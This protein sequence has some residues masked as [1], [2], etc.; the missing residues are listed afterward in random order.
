ML[1]LSFLYKISINLNNFFLIFLLLLVSIYIGF[2]IYY[3]Y[4]KLKK[5]LIIKKQKT[6]EI[7]NYLYVSDIRTEIFELLF[8][9]LFIIV[10]I[11]FIKFLNVEKTLNVI[12]FQPNE[13]V[14][15]KIIVICLS[16]ILLYVCLKFLNE[17]IKYKVYKIYLFTSQFKIFFQLYTNLR[18]RYKVT[19]FIYNKLHT[20]MIIK[21]ILLMFFPHILLFMA[22]SYDLKNKEIK[23][24]YYT[25][26]IYI[27]IILYRNIKKTLAEYDIFDIDSKLITYFYKDKIHNKLKKTT[28]K[29]EYTKILNQNKETMILYNEYEERI[30]QYILRNFKLN[31]NNNM[32]KI[33][34]PY[35]IRLIFLGLLSLYITFCYNMPY[36]NCIIISLPLIFSIVFYEIIN[37]YFKNIWFN[38]ILFYINIILPIYIFIVIYLSRNTLYF[39]SDNI[40]LFNFNF[41]QEF[42]PEEKYSFLIKNIKNKLYTY[43]YL[44]VQHYATIN[45]ILNKKYQYDFQKML[46]SM[47]IN[48]IK[49]FTILLLEASIILQEKYDDHITSLYLNL[50][51]KTIRRME[52]ERIRLNNPFD[53]FFTK[54]EDIICNEKTWNY[55]LILFGLIG[56]FS[57]KTIKE[58]PLLTYSQTIWD[59]IWVISKKL[60]DMFF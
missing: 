6:Y 50:Y 11:S 49:Q 47:N 18:K 26:Y 55:I 58:I 5:R 44:K 22:L 39:M 8:L 29:Y 33:Y 30:R 60:K 7:L 14:K 36:Y 40:L 56:R 35:K 9:N 57:E 32:N 42:T 53:R 3:Y 46:I 12:L 37:R 21:D 10:L 2:L 27:L 17:V 24:F 19:K 51:I 45:T 43:Q 15:Y 31:D 52:K 59:T 41:V 34:E 16:L 54:I 4:N 38:K 25:L 13:I 48:K 20:F 28:S 1:L 23:I